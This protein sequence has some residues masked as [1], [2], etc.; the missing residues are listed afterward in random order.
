MPWNPQ[1]G[2]ILHNDLE[3]VPQNVLITFNDAQGTAMQGV[4]YSAAFEEGTELPPNIR[5]SVS[6]VGVRL[7]GYPDL[8]GLFPQEPEPPQ[9]PS[10]ISF[11]QSKPVGRTDFSQADRE[12][13]VV[14][15][16]TAILPNGIKEEALF[17]LRVL[18]PTPF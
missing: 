5:L 14:L 18:R 10:F 8:R 17:V 3:T 6:D 2:S 9:T 16:V 4:T 13:S 12:F 1:V 7:R 15:N 11:K